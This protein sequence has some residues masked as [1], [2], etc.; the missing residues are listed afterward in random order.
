M[1]TKTLKTRSTLDKR[2]RV[3]KVWAISL[4]PLL[5][6]NFLTVPDHE[7]LASLTGFCIDALGCRLA[8]LA[9]RNFP[10]GVIEAEHLLRVVLDFFLLAALH[11][12]MVAI[13]SLSIDQL[14]T[15]TLLKARKKGTITNGDLTPH[16]IESLAHAR[17]VTLLQCHQRAQCGASINAELFLFTHCEIELEP[18]WRWRRR[19]WSWGTG[20][21]WECLATR[22]PGLD[23][24][25][26]P[27]VFPWKFAKCFLVGV[28]HVVLMMEI[29]P[30]PKAGCVVKIVTKEMI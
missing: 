29:P 15:S 7:R 2:T 5:P 17:C 16:W 6:V 10:C 12:E 11:G 3:G 26:L 13:R 8:V 28:H 25:N 20:W 19:A 22:K 18:T 1:F 27:H 21:S 4:N 9:V 24:G 14:D 23:V 30:F